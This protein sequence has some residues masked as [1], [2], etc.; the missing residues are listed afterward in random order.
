MGLLFSQ[1]E[2]KPGKLEVNIDN[3]KFTIENVDRYSLLPPE[4]CAETKN[5][6]YTLRNYNTLKI[7]GNIIEDAELTK[8]LIIDGLT[9]KDM[10]KEI[11]ATKYFICVKMSPTVTDVPRDLCL[12]FVPVDVEKMMWDDL[13][14]LETLKT[15][16][17]TLK[18]TLDDM[19][20]KISR[21]T[22]LRSGSK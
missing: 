3:I 5:L 21:L 13:N 2:Q 16:V 19:N 22:S 4:V 7:T 1:T 10:K 11:K 14:E 6:R 17:K 8:T 12:N 9:C 15:E 18:S 20:E